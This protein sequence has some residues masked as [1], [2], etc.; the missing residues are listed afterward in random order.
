MTDPLT[1][2]QTDLNTL[3][4]VTNGAATATA[5]LTAAQDVLA[6]LADQTVAGKTIAPAVSGV[7]SA[8]A[9]AINNDVVGALQAIATALGKL[10]G[11]SGFSLSG[12]ASALSALQNALQTAQ[13]LV[14]GGS[15]A[16]ASAFASTSQF[17]TLFG[18]L[19]QDASDPQGT[20]DPVG[21]LNEIALQLGAIATA[22]TN[23]AQGNP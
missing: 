4:T 7:Y 2:L 17:A 20:S 3:A 13:S 14:P 9:T 5:D 16:V 19:L 21:T 23:A 11:S 18:N 6:L 12:A 1:T 22:F 10:I 8:I 15:S